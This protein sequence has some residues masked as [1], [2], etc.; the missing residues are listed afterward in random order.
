MDNSLLLEVILALGAG[1]LLNLTPCVLPVIPIKVRTILRAAGAKPA[2]RALSAGL[3]AAGSLLF[4]TPLGLATALLHL[5]WGVLFQSQAVL[6][7]L[8]I[9]LLVMAVMNFTGRGLPIPPI[10]ARMGGGRFAEPLVSGLV[11]ALLSTP[12][13]GP[14]LGGI[15][16][17]ALTRPTVDIVMIFIAIGLG[18]A[19]P[20]AILLLKPGLLDR[21]PRGGAWTDIV[22][23]S[24]GWLLAGAA[25]FF[26]QSLFP[27][28]VDKTLWFAFLAGVMLWVLATSLRAADHASRWAAPL[29]S[30]PALALVYLSAGI[31]P[32]PSQGIPWQPLEATQIAEIANLHRPALVEFTAQWCLNCRFLE[33]TVYGDARVVQALRTRGVVPLQVDLTRPNPELQSLLAAYGGAGLPFVAILNP[34]GREI[35]HLSGLFSADALVRGLNAIHP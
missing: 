7:G 22:R 24:F 1:M 13:T 3:F 20:Y 2:T 9:I 31:W 19:L 15:L 33:Q 4:F 10:I 35:G 28:S 18:M 5:Q 6:T 16:V 26:A 27:A 34:H 21:L 11:S 23:Q 30:L 25:I 12:C 29:S 17:F 32:V 8:V 14:L